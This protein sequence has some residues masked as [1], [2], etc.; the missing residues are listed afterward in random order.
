LRGKMAD[1]SST[2][3][4][5]ADDEATA[6]DFEPE[7]LV[8]A[9]A[10]TDP[11]SPPSKDD[12]DEEY[13]EEEEKES[14]EEKE[15]EQSPEK[16]DKKDATPAAEKKPEA[17]KEEKKPEEKKDAKV[18]PEKKEEKAKEEEEPPKPKLT[19]V[20]MGK[21]EY[22]VPE[23]VAENWEKVVNWTRE[24][25]KKTEELKASLFEGFGKEPGKFTQNM[26]DLLTT[27]MGG[28]R[29]RAEELLTQEYAGVVKH[30]IDRLNMPEPERKALDA[31][32]RAERAEKE[33]E[34]IRKDKAEEE[35]KT[36]RAEEVRAIFG[37]IQGAMKE[38]GLEMSNGN[39]DLAIRASRRLEF[40]RKE[41]HKPSAKQVIQYERDAIER[42]R[43]DAEKKYVDQA[44]ELGD[45]DFATRFP[46]LIERARRLDL[47]RLK[48]GK[49]TSA[50]NSAKQPAPSDERK[51]PPR[52]R[53]EV[54][55]GD[56]LA[57]RNW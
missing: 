29:D 40:L 12:D 43:I 33:L 17:K 42:E 34:R 28:D 10:K 7:E 4:P 44:K 5:D 20:R 53:R 21:D 18:E 14:E 35:A 27:H 50:K 16:E 8:T 11:K 3:S 52:S 25:A 1:E 39:R 46:D 32:E 49:T 55:K 19:R 45:E 41:G 9:P 26:L 38:A 30:I 36:R 48:G 47:A 51:S 13:D 22:E 54:L 56:E 24:T 2:P 57:A 31:Q 37:E 6:A 23:P 15:E